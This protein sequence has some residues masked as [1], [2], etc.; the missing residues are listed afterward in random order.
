MT[1]VKRGNL[2]F[3]TK[4]QLLAAFKSVPQ[5]RTAFG[6][7]ATV[8]LCLYSFCPLSIYKIR[9]IYF[10]NITGAPYIAIKMNL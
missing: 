3:G 6:H 1:M 5:R 4:V 7:F 9:N 10:Q 8:K 2:K